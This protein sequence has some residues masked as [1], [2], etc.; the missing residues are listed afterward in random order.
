MTELSRA[1]ELS[2]AAFRL[3]QDEGL[4][5]RRAVAALNIEFTVAA[6]LASDY[7]AAGGEAHLLLKCDVVTSLKGA[8]PSWDGRTAESLVAAAERAL[9]EVRADAAREVARVTARA[10]DQ[11]E[12]LDAELAVVRS[13]LSATQSDVV[14]LNERL[15]ILKRENAALSATLEDVESARD[16]LEARFR[17]GVSASAPASG[18]SEA[19]GAA[20]SAAEGRAVE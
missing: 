13:R 9:E 2:A 6:Q 7:A 19:T 15:D 3:F 20:S 10:G 8:F 16:A 4:D 18:A 14:L 1:G 17:V 12:A 11:R 5:L